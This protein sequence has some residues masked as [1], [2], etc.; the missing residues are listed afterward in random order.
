M[1]K[2]H[3]KIQ[4]AAQKTMNY[5]EAFVKADFFHDNIQS[6]RKK[7]SIPAKGLPLGKKGAKQLENDTLLY[8]PEGFLRDKSLIKKISTD[9]NKIIDK[10]PL[11]NFRLKA[12]LRAYLFHDKLP[13]TLIYKAAQSDNLCKIIDSQDEFFEYCADD[14]AL[15]SIYLDHMRLEDFYYPVILRINPEAGQRDIVDYIRKNWDLLSYH[16]EKYKGRYGKLGKIKSHDSEI[17]RRNSLIYKNR[18]KKFSEIMDILKEECIPKKLR[19]NVDPGSIGK[20]KS[21]EKKR[22]KEV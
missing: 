22:R 6:C 8:F 13:Q 2:N 4:R 9:L 5:F 15:R 20:I 11:K 1:V 18:G 10:F 19:D 17:A 14:P 16:L 7:Y 3:K 12:L 21:L